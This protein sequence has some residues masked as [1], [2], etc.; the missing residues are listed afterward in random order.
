M[1][2]PR[3][4]LAEDHDLVSQGLRALLKDEYEV[5]GPVRE[6]PRV[7]K[8]VAQAQPDVLML[9]L[10]LPGR[11]G[12]D[13]IPDVRR[14]SPKTRILVVTMHADY[15]LAKSAFSLGALGFVPKDSDIRELN[16]AIK[17]VLAGRTYL[18]P[19]VPREHVRQ[20]TS[21]ALRAFQQL[22][23]QQQK[24]LRAI[25]AGASTEDIAH[26]LALSVHT[27]HWHRRSIRRTLGIESDDGL[28]R[29]AVML[30]LQGD[31]PYQ[32]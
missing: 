15:A 30:Q 17:E 16:W 6:G 22:T 5:L 31:Q 10:S 32:A 8:A 3:I 19:R 21:P 25:G 12:L 26:Q 28:T 1:R 2:K 24:V 27:I 14:M 9:D 13:L 29:F 18:S 20:P 23:P 7:P 11:N 4:L